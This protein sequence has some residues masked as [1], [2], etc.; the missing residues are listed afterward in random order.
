MIKVTYGGDPALGAAEAAQRTACQ[1]GISRVALRS[2]DQL[3]PQGGAYNGSFAMR[4]LP[5]LRIGL[6]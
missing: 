1:E 5:S 4:L 2:I 3:L 6:Q